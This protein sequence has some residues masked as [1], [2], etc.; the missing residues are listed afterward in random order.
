MLSDQTSQGG[1]VWE[2]LW[3]H[4]AYYYELHHNSK[5]RK[6]THLYIQQNDWTKN[7]A[8]S[9]TEIISKFDK[10]N[11]LHWYKRSEDNIEGQYD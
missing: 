10:E 1:E 11:L 5:A 7:I 9:N 4:L 8:V 6:N 2:D 3:W